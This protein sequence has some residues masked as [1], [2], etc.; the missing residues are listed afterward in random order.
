MPAI[1]F[2]VGAHFFGLARAMIG[3]GGGVFIWVG[4]LMCMS[5]SVV[6][7]GLARSFAFLGTERGHNRFQLRLDLMGLDL[8]D[9]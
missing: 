4:A 6:I 3:G 7:W 2:I 1:A 8:V 5:A 9:M